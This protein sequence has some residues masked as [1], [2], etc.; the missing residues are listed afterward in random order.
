MAWRERWKEEERRK[1]M[2]GVGGGRGERG[3]YYKGDRC[4]FSHLHS[5]L[6]RG[7]ELE[8]EKESWEKREWIKM[9]FINIYMTHTHIYLPKWREERRVRE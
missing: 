2:W 9:Q 1:E 5:I 7:R 6:A 4:I 3:K 8:K